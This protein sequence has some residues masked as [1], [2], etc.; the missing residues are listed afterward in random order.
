MSHLLPNLLRNRFLK[1][2][3]AL[4]VMLGGSQ[5]ASAALYEA[6]PANFG[7][8]QVNSSNCDDCFD[9]YICAFSGAGQSINF[10]GTTYTNLFVGSNGYVTFGT[11]RGVFSSQPLEPLKPSRP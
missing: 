10:F 6:N 11:G 7:A 1:A 4:L 5:I 3:A 2:A 8:V 9:D